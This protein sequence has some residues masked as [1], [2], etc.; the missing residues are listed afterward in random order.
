MIIMMEYVT[1]YWERDMATSQY[2]VS[3]KQFLI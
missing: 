3:T 2:L 1:K